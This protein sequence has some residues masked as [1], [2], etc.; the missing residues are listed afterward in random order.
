MTE[1]E[2]RGFTTTILHSDRSAAIEHGTLHE[3]LHLSVAYGCGDARDLA[4]L[5]QGR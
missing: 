1:R 3:P 5:F 4:A 2:A